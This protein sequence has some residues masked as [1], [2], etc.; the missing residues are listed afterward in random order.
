MLPALPVGL[1]VSAIIALGVIDRHREN[2][3][4]VLAYGSCAE[5]TRCNCP[6]LDSRWAGLIEPTTLSWWPGPEDDQ[7]VFNHPPST[8]YVDPVE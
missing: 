6:I 5:L 3:W 7:T 4:G 1:A 8:K 2:F